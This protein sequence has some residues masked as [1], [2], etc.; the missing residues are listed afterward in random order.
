MSPLFIPVLLLVSILTRQI[1]G[2][3]ATMPFSDE[4]LARIAE[5]QLCTHFGGEC[6]AVCPHRFIRHR[7]NVPLCPFTPLVQECCLGPATGEE[8]SPALSMMTTTSTTVVTTPAPEYAQCGVLP[9]NSL[10]KK[11]IVGGHA[12]SPGSW[13]WL[14]ALRSVMIGSHAC[15]AAVVSQRW[16]ITAAHCFKH[17]S[18]PTLWRVRVG[19]HNLIQHDDTE[20][21]IPIQEIIMHPG[22]RALPHNENETIYNRYVNDIALIRLAED[23]RVQPICLPASGDEAE[24]SNVIDVTPTLAEAVSELSDNPRFGPTV[25]RSQGVAGENEIPSEFQGTRRSQRRRDGNCWV[26]GWGVT[27]DDSTDDHALREVSG[28]VIGSDMCS[29]MWGVTLPQ[30]MVCF[31]DGTFG[32]CAGDSGG[33]LSCRRNGRFYLTGVVSWGTEGCNVSG[34]PSVFTRT[35][36]YLTWIQTQMSSRS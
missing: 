26:A 34:Y 24:V 21:D 22:Y 20:R 15:S 33:P 9:S 6:G 11:R 14:V 18:S 35:R 5:M 7:H 30:D 28:D 8:N 23:A 13:P 12:A 17:V 25:R 4:E 32:P 36:P 1:E 29:Q 27:R 19:E 2:T 3:A 16:V 10:R 31:G